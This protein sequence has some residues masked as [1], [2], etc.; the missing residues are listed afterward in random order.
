VKISE[1]KSKTDLGLLDKYARL[2]DSSIRIPGTTKSFGLDPILGLI[3]FVGSIVGYGFSV[4]LLLKI[5]Q[6]GASK[7]LLVKMFGNILLD[8]GIGAIPILGTLFDF[9]YKANERNLKLFREYHDEGKH[10]ESIM[11]YFIAFMLISLGMIL[12]MVYLIYQIWVW[13]F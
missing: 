3:P 10:S 8:A 12:A 1:D 5:A 4:L 11:P 2:L 9:V 6:H 7:L 13:I